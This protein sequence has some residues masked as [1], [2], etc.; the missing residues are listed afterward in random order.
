MTIKKRKLGDTN[1][2]ISEIGMGCMPLSTFPQRPS[3]SEALQTIHCALSLG[4]NFFNTSDAYCL[5]ESE[6]HH[7][8][9]LI[10]KAIQQYEGEIEDPIVATKGGFTRPKGRWIPNGNPD[11]LRKT[12]QESFIALGGVKPIDLWIYH[13]PDPDYDIRVSLEAAKDAVSEGK[14]RLVGVSNCSVEQVCHAREVIDIAVVENQFSPWWRDPEFDGM[15]NY[16]EQKDIIFLPW[17]PFGGVAGR[18]RTCNLEDIHV[19][20]EI[21]E[22]KKVSVYCIILAWLRSKSTSVVP[23]PGTMKSAEIKD[24]LQALSVYLSSE[25]ISKINRA[26]PFPK[27]KRIKKFVKQTLRQIS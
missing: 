2:T 6:K 16:C 20:F 10:C 8:E 14:V 5:D 3:E 18:R 24:S 21:A 26:M 7:N 25:E 1:L 27:I 22:I 11:Y 13:T 9:R 15:L 12:I 17:S 19:L 23:I 4:V